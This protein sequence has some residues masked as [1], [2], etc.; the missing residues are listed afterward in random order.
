VLNAGI[1]TQTLIVKITLENGQ[2]VTKKV[3][4]K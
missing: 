3:F 1:A 4:I 2:T